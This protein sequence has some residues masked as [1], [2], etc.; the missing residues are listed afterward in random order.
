[1]HATKEADEPRPHLI[2]DR[3]LSFSR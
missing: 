3:W 1:V 2:Q